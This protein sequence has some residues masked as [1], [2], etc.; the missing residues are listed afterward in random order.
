M[1]SSSQCQVIHWKEGHKGECHASKAN[2][3]GHTINESDIICNNGH[4]ETS[5]IA[6]SPTL[7][8]PISL[9]SFKSNNKKLNEDDKKPLSIQTTKIPCSSLPISGILPKPKTVSF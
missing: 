7:L 9:G 8:N 2:N 6:N 4:L 3:F 1:H 5:K